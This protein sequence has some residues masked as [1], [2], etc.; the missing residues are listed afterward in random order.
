MF[1]AYVCVCVC[2]SVTAYGEGRRGDRGR[3]L[4]LS[5]S[6]AFASVE[7]GERHG[8]LKEEQRWRVCGDR[9]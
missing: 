4:S 9:V 3:Q 5:T 7:E 2:V 1:H 6:G 8:R